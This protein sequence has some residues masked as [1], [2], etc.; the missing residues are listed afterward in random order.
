MQIRESLFSK[1][2]SVEN[3]N[4][5]ILALDMMKKLSEHYIIY[6]RKNVFE[7]DGP[8]KKATLVF[9]VV[10][11]LDK[12][13][14]VRVNF[15]MEGENSILYVD[16]KGEFVLKIKDQGFFT[17]VFTEFYLNNIFPT[18]RRVSEQRVKELNRELEKL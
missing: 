11:P 9:D 5:Y 10:E 18:L 7:T 1:G 6:E 15:S 13:S 4:P 12:F 17:E 16:V 8:V 2:F 3:E 14:H